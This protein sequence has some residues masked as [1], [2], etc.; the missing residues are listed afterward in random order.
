MKGCQLRNP[1]SKLGCHRTGSHNW[2]QCRAFEISPSQK[3]SFCWVFY[4]ACSHRGGS[5]SCSRSGRSQFSSLKVSGHFPLSRSP[6]P[7]P[8]F[9]F[10]LEI[11]MDHPGMSPK[12]LS[13]SAPWIPRQVIA[14]HETA[15]DFPNKN[16]STCHFSWM[17]W[18][19]FL[20]QVTVQ[21]FCELQVSAVLAPPGAGSV[22]VTAGRFFSLRQVSVQFE[23][24][25]SKYYCL[26]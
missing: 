12:W 23:G 5:C 15:F 2:S 10:P 19:C 22:S 14:V 20:A 16:N 11:L 17:K 7:L 18:F 6:E 1:Q 4:F 21:C 9:R 26:L 8:H 13:V 24:L 3:S 25:K